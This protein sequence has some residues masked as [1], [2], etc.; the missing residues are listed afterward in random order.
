MKVL[1]YEANCPGCEHAADG[2]SEAG[3]AGDGADGGAWEDIRDQREYIRRPALMCGA[4]QADDG[5]DCPEA[6][7]LPDE[8]NGQ[9][10]QRAG[11]HRYAAR[12]ADAKAHADTKSR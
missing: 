1:Q 4:C 2:S 6:M 5:D 8:G 7:H 11:Q 3:D 10:S 9:C 12:D